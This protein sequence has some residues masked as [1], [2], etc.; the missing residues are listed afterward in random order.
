MIMITTTITTATITEGR[1][2]Q[3]ITGRGGNA[4]FD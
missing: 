4:R 1:A 3:V 2:A